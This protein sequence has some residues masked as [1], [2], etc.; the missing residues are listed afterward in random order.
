MGSVVGGVRGLFARIIAEAEAFIAERGQ[1]EPFGPIVAGFEP[2][3]ADE[4]RRAAA[5][6]APTIRGLAGTDSAVVGHFDDCEVVLDFVAAGRPPRGSCRSAR[7]APTTSSAPRCGRCCSTCRRPRRWPIASRGCA[8]CTRSTAASTPRTTSATPTADSPP[9]RGADPAIVLVPG[10]GMFS[11]GADAADGAHR[12]RVL[13]QRDQRDARRR[14]GVDL[15][16]GARRRRS[17]GSSTGR[18]KRPSCVGGPPRPLIGRV[19]LV[20]GAGFGHRTGDRA[21]GSRAEGAAVVVTDLA[22]AATSRSWTSR[23]RR[24][25]STRGV[26]AKPVL[27]VSAAS[28]SSSTTPGCRSRSRSSTPRS[29]TGT[30]STT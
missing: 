11:F 5:E 8:S 25:R 13:R 15:R 14:G 21:S 17:S 18:S 16:A 24:L 1:A 29:K 19:A 3:D 12:R 4:R 26:L 20:T 10:V 28:T 7:R 2:L 9:M 22:D 30:V 6:L 27:R 23:D